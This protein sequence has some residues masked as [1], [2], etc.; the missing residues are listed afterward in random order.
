M[1][2]ACFAVDPQTPLTVSAME[3]TERAYAPAAFAFYRLPGRQL[4]RA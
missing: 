4:A 2:P 1:K 3:G